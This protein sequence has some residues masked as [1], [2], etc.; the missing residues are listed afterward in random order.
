ME[1]F[2]HHIYEFRKG[3]RN[4]VL[5]TGS[6]NELSSIK[7]RLDQDSISYLIQPVGREK[8]NVFFGNPICVDVVSRFV[9]KR[10][11]DLTPEEDFMLGIMLGYDR[12]QQCLR[13]VKRAAHDQICS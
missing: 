3:L 2:I 5:Y 8:I 11:C 6:L 4:L 1:V 13:Y 9:D 12:I 10:L 7:K